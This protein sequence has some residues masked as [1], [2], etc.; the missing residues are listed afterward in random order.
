MICNETEHP[1]D[2]GNSTWRKHQKNLNVLSLSQVCRTWRSHI[3]NNAILWTDIAFDASEERSIKAAGIFLKMIEKLDL[4]FCVYAG[5]G[6]TVDPG[7]T[8]LLIELRPLIP[9]IRHFQYTGKV[10]GYIRYLDLPADSLYHFIG[11]VDLV[12]FS[13][14]MT[15]LHILTTRPGLAADRTA[16]IASI[17][18]LTCLELEPP[19][20]GQ[21]IPLQPVLD[22][23]RATP[24][25][26]KLKLSC[27]GILSDEAGFGERVTL[28]HLEILELPYSDFQ[29]AMNHLEIPNAREV[30]YYGS[31]Y[32][33]EY[34]T[35]APLFRSPHMFANISS[36]PTY[37]R[38]VSEVGV[39]TALDGSISTFCVN[40][41]TRDGFS[42]DIR[43][44]WFMPRKSRWEEY[45]EGSL[46]G[47]EEH[48][49][50][51]TGVFACFFFR[52]PFSRPPR[53]P[54]LL[55][56]HIHHLAIRGGFGE[57]LMR[58][59]ASR[60]GSQSWLPEL[61]RLFIADEVLG[62]DSRL[63]TLVSCL[64]ARGTRLTVYIKR[65]CFLWADLVRLGCDV[66][67]SVV[68][69][70]VAHSDD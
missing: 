25:I 21:E 32:P 49:S 17:P 39:V 14:L 41:K 5:F 60:S 9:R 50:L 28:R 19:Y 12:P 58:R 54:F 33:P 61:K 68:L 66:E 56:P 40:L 30:V 67:G 51:S 55:S 3:T 46:L 37:G 24:R 45:I 20:L 1:P 59:L 7:I 22:M 43:M 13:G 26:I 16:W 69:L 42:L 36:F 53:L 4:Q 65:E 11:R 47:L 34:N 57:E 6:E 64:R 10:E 18:N 35:A 31:E 62:L 63:D 8:N 27:F 70:T 29:T 44:S 23:L 2:A 15:A 48:V 52:I 38:K